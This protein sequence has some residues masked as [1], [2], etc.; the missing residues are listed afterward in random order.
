M[1]QIK[2]ISA[3][4]LFEDAKNRVSVYDKQEKESVLYILFEDVFS[5]RKISIVSGEIISWKHEQQ[6]LLDNSIDRLNTNEPV[7]Y[8]IGKSFF[9]NRW[10]TVSKDVLIPRP[11]T[12]ELVDLILK[13]NTLK[14][15][16]IL[17]VGTGSGCI[18]ISLAAEIPS[19]TVTAIDISKDAL[20]IAEGNAE[21]NGVSVHFKEL[22]FLT[23]AGS[24]KDIFD[25]I[26]SNPP[27]V[28]DSEKPQMNNNVLL[29]E[30][31]LALFVKD[32]NALIYYD[33]LF[34]FA[35]NKLH[36]GGCVYVEINEQ[37]GAELI[38]LAQKH[39]LSDCEIIKDLFG[40][41]RMLT[42]FK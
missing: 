34:Q 27:Y 42:A 1:N 13:R 40:K 21:S 6:A 32:T 9:Y 37:K 23:N 17:D 28:L 3:K 41:D 15:P 30:P 19:S 8:I 22:D 36:K 2:E 5:I 29:F 16:N 14:N 10:F 4:Y 20:S 24:I 31:H 12:E 26:V 18:A 7:Q 39:G 11:E 25:I 35:F 33:I 38:L